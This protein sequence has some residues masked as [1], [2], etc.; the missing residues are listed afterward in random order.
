MRSVL[1]ETI[2]ALL[3]HK[4]PRMPKRYA[5]LSPTSLQQAVATLSGSPCGNKTGTQTG[6]G[7][8]VSL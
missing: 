5:H 7:T 3:G 8:G 4:D 2:G 6:A 1:L